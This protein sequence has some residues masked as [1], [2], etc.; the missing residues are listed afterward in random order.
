MNRMELG[1]GDDFS[2]L[3]HIDGL[4]VDD[5]EALVADVE[6]PEVDTKVVCADVRLAIRVDRDRVNVIGMRVCIDLTWYGGDNGVDRCE[7]RQTESSTT[8]RHR[9]RHWEQ[10]WVHVWITCLSVA[11]VVVVVFG[12]QL[13]CLFKHFPELDR[14]VCCGLWIQEEKRRSTTRRISWLHTIRAEEL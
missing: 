14:L 2:E 5:V 11:H 3:F 10:G 13:E 12:Y 6:V 1:S 9:C 8:S 4:D 7:A